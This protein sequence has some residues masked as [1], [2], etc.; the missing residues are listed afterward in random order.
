MAEKDDTRELVAK[1]KTGDRSAFEAIV[2]P[3]R[4]RLRAAAGRQLD[5]GGRVVA[6]VDDV[7]QETFLRAFQTMDRFE[8]RGED[9]LYSWLHGI[10]RKVVLKF[11][12]KGRRTCTL[13]LPDRVPAKEVPPSKA[14]RREE[15]FDRLERCL[16]S[17][18]PEYREVLR[19]ARLEGL[20][21]GE[22]AKRTN[23]TEYAVKHLLARGI[24][25]L[26]EAFGN[27]ESLHLPPRSLDQRGESDAER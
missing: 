19:L 4:D 13:E 15:R 22:I 10:A 6:E 26:R 24:R 11:L 25:E 8:W 21:A 17:L 5:G 16:G 18:R 1:A 14:A 9:S 23:R 27:T 3:L 20:T 12:E 7:L 2:E